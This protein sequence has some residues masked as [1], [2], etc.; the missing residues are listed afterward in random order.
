MLGDEPLLRH[1]ITNLVDNANRHARE[2][3]GSGSD[4]V[5]TLSVLREQDRVVLQVADDGPGFTDDLDVR[6]EYVSGAGGGTGLGLPLVLW[7]AGRHDAVVTLRNREEG[8]AV[9]AV[10]FPFASPQTTV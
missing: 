8:G 10:S 5:V 9:V 4:P 7:I 6:V 1:L 2:N 3:T